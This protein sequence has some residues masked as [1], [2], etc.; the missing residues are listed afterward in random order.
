MKK[1]KSIF[2]KCYIG[3]TIFWIIFFGNMNF[4]GEQGFHIDIDDIVTI[5]LT[6]SL[7]SSLILSAIIYALSDDK[8]EA[9]TNSK[10]K[11]NKKSKSK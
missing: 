6:W 7:F 1:Y 3:T 2:L 5:M 9:E 10:A 4:F 8:K 11:N